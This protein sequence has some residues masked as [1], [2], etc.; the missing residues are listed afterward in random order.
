MAVVGGKAPATSRSVVVSCIASKTSRST[1][2][3]RSGRA[4]PTTVLGGQ[5][6]KNHAGE[7][8]AVLADTLEANFVG[9]RTP[10][11]TAEQAATAARW[12]PDGMAYPVNHEVAEVPVIENELPAAFDLPA[13]EYP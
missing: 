1:S 6:A 11:V 2:A 9:N 12:L 3:S 8:K 4:P 13:A 5:W 7:K 10:G